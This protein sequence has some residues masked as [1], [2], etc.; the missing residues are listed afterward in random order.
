MEDILLVGRE[1][2]VVEPAFGNEYLGVG[3]I[4]SRV[5]G[6]VLIYADAGL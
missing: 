4:Q 6:S 1:T 2:R 3:E 5:V